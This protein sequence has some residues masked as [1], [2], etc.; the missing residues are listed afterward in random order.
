[1]S[2]PGDVFKKAVEMGA[3][4]AIEAYTSP[5]L[6]EYGRGG[7]TRFRHSDSQDPGG[8]SPRKTGG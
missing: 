6:V 7:A 8:L 4:R 3:G 2:N 5:N 1:M